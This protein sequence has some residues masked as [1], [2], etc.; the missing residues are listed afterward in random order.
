MIDDKNVSIINVTKEKF[1]NESI[2]IE[3]LLSDHYNDFRN[4]FFQNIREIDNSFYQA[5]KK[6]IRN[7]LNPYRIFLNKHTE[8]SKDLKELSSLL[9]YYYKNSNFNNTFFINYFKDLEESHKNKSKSKII[10]MMPKDEIESLNDIE[11][12]VIIIKGLMHYLNTTIEDRIQNNIDQKKEFFT[13]NDFHMMYKYLVI[14]IDEFSIMEETDLFKYLISD[15]IPFNLRRPIND[16][17]FYNYYP[18]LCK[19]YCQK[20]AKMFFDNFSTFIYS[21]IDKTD[22]KRCKEIKEDM[23]VIESQIKSLYLKTCIFSH[24]INE[25]MFHPLSFFTLKSY[26]PFYQKIFDKQVNKELEEIVE[27]TEITENYKNLKN[28]EIRKIYEETKMKEIY[29]LLNEYAKKKEIYGNSCY[30]SEYKTEPCPIKFVPN[31]YDYYIHMKKC[32][33]YHSILERRRITKNT[34]N[35][36]CKGVIA[37]KK[38]INDAA[39]I[40]CNEKD[41]KKYHNRNELF[42]DERNYR[43]LYPCKE[44]FYCEKGDLCPKKHATDIKIE[45]IYLPDK[46]KNKLERSLKKLINK[47]DKVK[48]KIDKLYKVLCKSCLNYIDGIHGRNIYI[49]Q[50]CKHVICSKCYDYYKSCPLCG[51]DEYKDNKNNKNIIFIDLAYDYEDDK[52]N[53]KQKESEDENYEKEDNDLKMIEINTSYKRQ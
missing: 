30:L 11:R 44:P 46:N 13:N 20:E 31:N 12:K 22:C 6:E 51:F 4:K 9:K 43:K 28:C 50:S 52:E 10:S 23:S 45:E 29:N 53:E 18:I 36:I 8:I 3:I 37:D 1:E 19:G 32:P 14:K 15:K 39:K 48:T 33:Y 27:E 2:V 5:I 40:D 49:F 35:K 34:E 41:C 24:N 21:H 47:D 38:W 7:N 17:N 26:F 42:F 25:I 16:Y